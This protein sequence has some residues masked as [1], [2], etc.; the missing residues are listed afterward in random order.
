MCIN[1]IIKNILYK[2]IFIQKNNRLK[3]PTEFLSPSFAKV[4]DNK[5]HKVSIFIQNVIDNVRKIRFLRKAGSLYPAFPG[6]LDL[7]LSLVE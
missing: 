3:C 1:K 7:P 5:T 2:H 6:D 4:V